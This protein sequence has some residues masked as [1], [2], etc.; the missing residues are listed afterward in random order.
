MFG[1][2]FSEIMVICAVALLV[3]G[4]KNL[5]KAARTIGRTLAEL[6]RTVDDIKKEVSL[7]ELN[8]KPESNKHKES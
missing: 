8:D 4:P 2:G 3:L 6:R 7:P 1:L 5:P